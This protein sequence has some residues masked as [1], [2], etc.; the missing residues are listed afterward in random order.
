M[1]EDRIYKNDMDIFFVILIKVFLLS[2]GGW[3]VYTLNLYCLSIN[4]FNI[5]HF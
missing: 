1:I 5:L 3:T 4:S 2:F